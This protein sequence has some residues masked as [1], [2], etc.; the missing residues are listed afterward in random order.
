MLRE[1]D[2][3]KGVNPVPYELLVASRNRLE[4]TCTV[5]CVCVCVPLFVVVGVQ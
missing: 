5:I 2:E 1:Y 4:D 3:G